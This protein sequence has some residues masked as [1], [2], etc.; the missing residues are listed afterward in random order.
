ME[1]FP[2]HFFFLAAVVVMTVVVVM[3]VMV[4]VMAVMVVV[5]DSGDNGCTWRRFRS[6][7]F[8]FSLACVFCFIS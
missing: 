5:I 2:L 6:T 3:A 4:V 8:F 7:S 1:A